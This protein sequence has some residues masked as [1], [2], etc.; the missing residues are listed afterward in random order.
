MLKLDMHVHTSYS[1][2]GRV[3]VEKVLATCLKRGLSG[4]AITDHNTIKG[5]LALKKIAPPDFL[6]IVGEEIKTQEGEIIGYFLKEEIPQG[7]SL[8]E[9][10]GS[11]RSQD[12]LV[13]V[14]HPCDSFRKSKI[15]KE[16]LSRI[17]DKVDILEVFNSR[18]ILNKDNQEAL[19]L[20]KQHNLALLVGSDAHLA[21]EIGKS[22]I[23]IDDF[24]NPGQF[25]EKLR[26]AKLTARKSPLWVHLVT[27][28][29][30]IMKG[31]HDD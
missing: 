19:G 2:C 4:A 11:I 26:S 29:N 1:P 27:K 8:E 30:K 10:M 23:E 22:Y 25:L 24:V 6:V 5:A 12:A 9:T 14:P 17:I 28:Y 18:N 13:A 3:S 31:G 20:A 7:L 16:A 21:C 15:T